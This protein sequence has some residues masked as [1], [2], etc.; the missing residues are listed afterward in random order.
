MKSE[1]SER[2]SDPAHRSLRVALKRHR[3]EVREEEERGGEERSGEERSGEER[4]EEE[5]RGVG[6]RGEKWEG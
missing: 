3:S 1:M 4:R 6:R 5:K 2:R